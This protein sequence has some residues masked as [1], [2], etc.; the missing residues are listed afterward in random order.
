[1][2]SL[3]LGAF[4]PIS[5]KWSLPH[6]KNI[7][8]RILCCNIHFYDPQTTWNKFVKKSRPTRFHDHEFV[9]DFADDGFRGA[10]TK[11]FY[12]RSIPTWNAL[13]RF[14]IES[15]SIKSF[16]ESLNKAWEKLMSTAAQRKTNLTQVKMRV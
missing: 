4:A 15:T 10:Q 1:M 6:K 16:K 9:P 13:P 8:I 12:Y 5:P 2:L 11:S 14:V 7:N 3:N